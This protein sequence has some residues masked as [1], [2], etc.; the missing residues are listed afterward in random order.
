MYSHILGGAY[1][2]YEN[3]VGEEIEGIS[4]SSVS[5]KPREESISRFQHC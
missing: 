3:G 4:E 5:G 1:K 2:R